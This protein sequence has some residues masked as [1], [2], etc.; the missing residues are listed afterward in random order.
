MDALDKLTCQ[1]KWF[2]HRHCLPEDMRAD[3][4]L[5]MYAGLTPKEERWLSRFVERWDTEQMRQSI[6]TKCNS[7]SLKTI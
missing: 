4:L 3:D 2:C 1:L 7:A 6:E 5:A